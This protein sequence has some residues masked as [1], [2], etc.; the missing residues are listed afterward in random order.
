MAHAAA[1][2]AAVAEPPSTFLDLGSGGGVPG[3]VLAEAW[4]CP[5]VLLDAQA[6]RGEFLA[7]ALADLDLAGSVVV[8]RAEEAAR[9]DDLRGAFPL[10]TSRSFGPPAVTAECGA[11]F[12]A[13]DGLLVVAEP[14]EAAADRWPA[15][16]LATVG[17]ADGGL[18][19]AG[20]ARVRVLR[21]VA[22]LPGRLPRRVGVPVKRPLW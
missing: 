12:L 6:R 1:F 14:P 11:A 2:L 4:G 18:V 9:R 19:V 7:T 3:L 22:P 8:A 13:P 17:L 10:V 5:V 16:G 21:A 20:D 15:D